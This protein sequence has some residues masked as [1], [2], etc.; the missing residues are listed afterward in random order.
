MDALSIIV[1]IFLIVA[2]VFVILY[3]V[4]KKLQT[5]M[6]QSQEM[7]SQNKMMQSILVI[8]KKKM[9]ITEA[10]LPKMVVDQVP[11]YY[12]FRKMPLVKAKIGPKITTLICDPKVFK[13]L[14]TKKMVKVEL[15]G[16]Y[17]V[18]YKDGKNPNANK[19]QEPKW[20]FWKKNKE[21]K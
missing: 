16:L 6:D 14:P 20:K 13:T 1:I 11:K 12:R 21:E 2:A 7:I 17:I 8:D 9:K 19:K 15:A 10:N 4:G 18:G 3:F 5:K